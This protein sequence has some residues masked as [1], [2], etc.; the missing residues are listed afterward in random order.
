MY[1]WSPKQ[2]KLINAIAFEDNPSI[3][4]HG[5]VQSGKSVSA[6]Y[7]FMLRCSEWSGY[8]FLLCSRS[9]RQLKGA[10]IKYVEEAC[11]VM[12]ISWRARNGYYE[13]GNF[14]GGINRF[15]TLLGS[16]ASSEGR[17][18]SFTVA[19]AMIDEATLV[20]E[21]FI[22]SVSDR[23][24]VPG[25][26]ILLITN[27]DSPEHHLHRNWIDAGVTNYQFGLDDNPILT[28][29]YVAGLK[30][31]YSGH[32]LQ[33]MVYG[34]WVGAE[35]AIFPFYQV[36]EPPR[37][38]PIRYIL[39]CDWARSS[40]TAAVLLAEYADG[41]IM[42]INEWRHDGTKSGQLSELDQAQIIKRDLVGNRHV[43]LIVTDPSAPAFRKAMEYVFNQQVYKAENAVSE[44]IQFVRQ[45]FENKSLVISPV[46]TGLISELGNYRYDE[47][48]RLLGEDKPIKHNDHSIDGLRYGM[49]S[50]AKGTS[51]KRRG[52]RKASIGKVGRYGTA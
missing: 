36:M 4:A 26:Q 22:N 7:G 43:A 33:R 44:G 9:E 19:G 39:G 6:A 12:G 24:S 23:C 10:V 25:A 42:A 30:R 47:R 1:E 28:D 49:Y 38:N 31:R 5:C 52:R 29:E 34:N 2:R 14:H 46:C 45:S 35:D 51:D 3:L 41:T 37:D 40:V 15:F 13:A 8:D 27:P 20:P 48:W 17:A 16:D 18:R 21:S 32:M 50:W 11:D